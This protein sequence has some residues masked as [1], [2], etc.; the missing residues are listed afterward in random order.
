MEYCK[1]CVGE[2]CE[3]INASERGGSHF[4]VLK[5]IFQA[6]WKIYKTGISI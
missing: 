3:L 4:F 2:D 5:N 1:N 6:G